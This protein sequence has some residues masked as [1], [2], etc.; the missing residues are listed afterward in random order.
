MRL[1]GYER[2]QFAVLGILGVFVFVG[3]TIAGHLGA[4]LVG[5][6]GTAI[7]GILFFLSRS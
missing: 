2:G 7:C 4:M 5:L 6:A 3:G 1:T